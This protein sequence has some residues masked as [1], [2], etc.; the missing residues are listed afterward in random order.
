MKNPFDYI[1]PDRRTLMKA[2]A[3]SAHCK[4][5]RRSSFRRAPPTH[6]DRPRQSADRHLCRARQ[7]RADRLPAR[8]RADQRQRRHPRP[9]GRT[10]GRGLDQR[11]RRHRRAEGAQADRARQGRFL[12]GNV[13][14][15]LA[16]RDGAGQRTRRRCCTSSRRPHRRGHRHELPL[17]RLPRLQHDAMEAN[18]V[19]EPAHQEV[20][21]EVVLHHARLRLRPHAAGRPRG[22]PARS[23]AAPRSAPTLTPLGTTDFSVLPDQGAGGEPRRHHRSCSRATTWSTRS[24][25]RCSSASTSRFH[26][27]GAQQELEVLE[28]LPPEARIGT[29]VFEWYWNQP[30]VPH[31]EE[32]VADDP[33]EQRRQS[34]DGAHLVRLRLGAGPAR[35]PPTRRRSLEAVKMAKA[36]AGLQAAARSRAAC[37]T[38]AYYRAGDNQLMPTLYVGNAQSQGPAAIPKICSRS[39]RWSRAIEAAPPVERDRLQDDLADLTLSGHMPRPASGIALPC[40][41]AAPICAPLATSAAM[42]QLCCSTSST[43]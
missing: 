7:E 41:A 30:G 11:R 31:V 17:E 36:L 2:A 29:W 8:D 12:L 42:T 9:Q 22:E 40:G 10:A 34:A 18:A 21:Q 37:R 43:G 25:R 5:H 6:Q 24:S 23:S 38:S 20:R 35:S 26:L 28:G 39:T 3:G 32:F 4:S 33:Q 19:A 15:A 14:S 13:N 27:A 1:V 16:A